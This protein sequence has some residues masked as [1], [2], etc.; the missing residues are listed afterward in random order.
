MRKFLLLLCIPLFLG[1]CVEENQLFEEGNRIVL[2][3]GVTTAAAR[4]ADSRSIV[5]NVGTAADRINTVGIYVARISDNTLYPGTSGTGSVFTAPAVEGGAWTSTTPVYV[6]GI[7]GRLFAWSPSGQAVTGGNSSGAPTIPVSSIP[8]AQTFNG[9]NEYTCSATDYMYG[10][11]TNTP[12]SVEAIPVSNTAHT[13]TIYMQHALAQIAI[14]MVNAAD[15]PADAAYDYVKKITLTANN[16][17][18][19]FKV[20]SSGG[21]MSL[22]DGALT[23]QSNAGELIFTPSANPK[24]VGAVGNPATVAYG[25]VVP[26]AEAAS[27]TTVKLSLLLGEAS[28][29]KTDTERLLV[30]ESTDAF[31]KAWEKGKRYV[32]TLTL[33]KR[34]ITISDADIKGWATETGN[35]NMPPVMD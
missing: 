26:K 21:T 3:P 32:Y 10:A 17:A 29:S 9:E 33:G 25:L 8:A 14:R 7:A 27:G 30:I 2:Q 15:R 16:G 18:T 34:G 20:I 6:H 12:G 4:P 1:G 23:G 31:N 13:P 11:G 22:A 19:P 24:Q 35:K 28:L 5:N